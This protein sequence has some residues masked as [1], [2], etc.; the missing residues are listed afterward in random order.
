MRTLLTLTLC[1]LLTACAVTPLRPPADPNAAR[2]LALYESVDRI[3]AEQGYSPSSPARIAGFPYLRVNRFLASYREQPLNSTQ[4]T[5]WLE[6][7]AELDRAARQIELSSLP[8]PMLA[9]L[10]ARQTMAP[11]LPTA[12]QHC[13]RQLQTAD[14]ADPE[15]F[16]VLRER[17]VVPPD[18]LTWRQILGLYPLSSLPISFGVARWHRETYQTFAQ[19]LQALPVQGRLQRFRPPEETGQSIAID[20]L[21]RDALGIPTPDARQLDSLF[22]T[23]APVWEID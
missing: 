16:T 5:A 3:V 2:C 11:N 20:T 15:R 14:L 19:P 4:R 21:P 17:A 12:L 7:L 13:S 6:H 10:T 1:C 8:A 18:Y 23:Y 22:A 9:E